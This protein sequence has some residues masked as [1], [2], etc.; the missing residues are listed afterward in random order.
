MFLIEL[1]I[2]PIALGGLLFSSG[3]TAGAEYFTISLP[4]AS[5]HR[6]LAL[7]AFLGGFSGSAGMVMVAAVALSTLILNHLVMPVVLHL[8]IQARDIRNNFV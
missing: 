7:F 8:D 4:L 1:F 2:I 3:E 6:W 5:G